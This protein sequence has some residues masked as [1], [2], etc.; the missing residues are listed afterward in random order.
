M[1]V[2]ICLVARI[3]QHVF[4]IFKSSNVFYVRVRQMMPVAN[5][6]PQELAMKRL[7]NNNIV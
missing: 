6:P 4:Q 5:G 2:C 1:Y 3:N 7:Y